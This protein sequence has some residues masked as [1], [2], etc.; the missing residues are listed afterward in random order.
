MVQVQRG[1]IDGSVMLN[2]SNIAELDTVR[3][4]ES[5]IVG[6]LVSHK[7]LASEAALLP[8]QALRDA[9]RTVGGWQTQAMGTLGGNVCN[10]SPAADTLP[11]LLIYDAEVTVK[12]TAGGERRIKL[13]DFL[14]GCRTTVLNPDELLTGISLPVPSPQAFSYYYKVGRRGAM[15]IAIAGVALYLELDPGDA[16]IKEARIAL[17]SVAPK[18]FRA[19]ETECML[20]GQA[21]TPE[22]AAAAGASLSAVISPIDDVRSTARYREMVVPRV[23]ESLLARC[24][25]E[26]DVQGSGT[27][28]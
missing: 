16:A 8:F 15:E 20:V 19:V 11:P 6:A 1:E 5:T 24:A 9:A 26:L 10:A 13:E 23:L 25:A 3:T 2:I 22:L 7:R 27:H 17:G 21:L 14:C 12:S 18:P 4:G 28:V